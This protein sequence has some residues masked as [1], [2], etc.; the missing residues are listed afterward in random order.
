M[1]VPS[2]IS[3]IFGGSAPSLGASTSAFASG[4]G[5]PVGAEGVACARTGVESAVVEA[6]AAQ[7]ANVR[8]VRE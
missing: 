8:E 6:K 5:A 3:S 7:E 4:G 1:L 2:V